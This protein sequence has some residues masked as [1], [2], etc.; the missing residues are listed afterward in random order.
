MKKLIN[1]LKKHPRQKGF[2][3][4]E[5]VVV[6][7]IVVMLMI[8]IAPNLV[9]Q[10]GHA[11]QKTD[12]AFRT[13]LQTQVELYKDEHP[14]EKMTSLEPLKSNKYLTS[15][16]QKKLNKYSLNS[17]GE[18]IEKSK[19]FTVL[20]A[21]ITLGIILMLTTI[22]VWQVKDYRQTIVFKNTI[23]SFNTA[24][25]QAVRVATINHEAIDVYYFNSDHYLLFNGKDYHKKVKLASQVKISAINDYSISANGHI[26]P[27]SVDFS[28]GKNHQRVKI[29]MNWGKKIAEN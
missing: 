21:I 4:I 17:D 27:K 14:D 16:Q 23:A 24:I 29:Q 8:I 20:E 5:M 12:D 2:T 15:D 19:G 7:A 22:G 25:D 1:L 13:T 18:V 9:K 28:D 26:P 10:K 3:L 11:Q 6:I